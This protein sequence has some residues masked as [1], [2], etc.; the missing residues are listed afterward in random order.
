MY[1]KNLVI[2]NVKSFRGEHHFEFSPGVN[3]LVGD[4][5]TG[6]STVLESLLFLFEK[7]TKFTPEKFYSTNVA[8][9]TRVQVDIVSDLEMLVGE[10]KFKKLADY[11]F[12]EEGEQVLRLDRCSEDRVVTQKGKEITIKV[13]QVAFWHNARSQFENVTG[14]DSLVRSIFDFE[15]IWADANPGDHLDFASNKTLGRLLESSFRSF[16]ESSM[17]EELTKAHERAFSP[18][19]EGSFLKETGELAANIKELVDE[20]YGTAEYRFDF[21]LPE[22]SVFMKQGSLQVDDGQGETAVDSKGYGMQRAIALGVVQLYA[23]ALAKVDPVKAAPLILMLD[24][25]E[26]WMHPNAQLKLG[27]ALSKIGEQ[28]QVFVITHSPYLI[29]KFDSNNHLLTVFSGKASDRRIDVSTKFGLFG[30]GEPTW[31]EINYRAFG[32]YSNEFHNELYGRVQW[33][34]E[35]GKQNGNVARER[36]VDEFF[37][38]RG[39]QKQKEWVRS[40]GVSYRRTLP[41]FVRNSIHHP[42]NKLNRP[43]TAEEL[44]TSTDYLIQII[45]GINATL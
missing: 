44:K 19:S 40:I 39:L 11:I 16:T 9:P 4:N 15:A 42:E 33:H 18:D 5:N 22:P 10:D 28:E 20:Q 24:E 27:E 23:R 14:I 6:K 8:E 29:R 17:W 38:Q 26:T 1:I 30:V 43:V 36:E 37:A 25:P 31:G 13:A 41:T 21:G 2:E 7:P 35:Q 34:I 45:E 12:T 3:F 32:I